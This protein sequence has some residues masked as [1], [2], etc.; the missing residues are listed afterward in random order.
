MRGFVA[1]LVP[2]LTVACGTTEVF[3]GD[4]PGVGRVVA[5]IVDVRATAVPPEGPARETPLGVPG[6]VALD[7]DGTFFFTD[8]SLR[9]VGA[10]SREGALTWIAG[11]GPGCFTPGPGP[12]GNPQT[13]CFADPVSLVRAPD[14]ALFISDLTGNR[15]YRWDPADS[16]IAVVIGTGTADT[17]RAGT[18]AQGSP[19][20][21][22]QGL[23]V[24]DDGTLWVVERSGHRVLRID[25]DGVVRVV[26]GTGFRGE[27]GDG[28]PAPDA[29]LSLPEGV[30]V[31]GDTVFIADA[32]NHRIRRVVDGVIRNYA[33]IGIP[34]LRG[35]GDAVTQALFR[36]PS[37]M[38]TLGRLLFVVDRGNN[39]VRLIQVGADSII[40][41][42]GSGSTG[43]GPDG[44]DI[45]RTAI[46]GPQGIAILGRT[47]LIADSGAAVVRR[48]IR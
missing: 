45:R 21:N 40:T 6:G 15:V 13:T 30:A 24:A 25:P 44:E 47:V 8:R 31:M 32:G 42:A 11:I 48:V 35:D 19:V 4:T 41:W 28:G 33:G 14:G 7:P 12:G 34:G 26:A 22:P 2:A 38:V 23:A 9:R 29:Q 10:V 36:R 43:P 16:S 27:A 39:R 46:G 17:A 5:G 20:Y 37:T 18:P 1:L 3:Y